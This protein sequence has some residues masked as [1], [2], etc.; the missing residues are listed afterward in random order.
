MGRIIPI[1]CLILFVFNEPLKA[2]DS[3]LQ[4]QL[5]KSLKGN[6]KDVEVDNLNNIYLISSTNQIKKLNSNF[7]SVAVFNDT[8]RFGNINSI[9]VN[10]PLKI[11][12]FYKEFSTIVVL[13]RFLNI[14]NTIDL[15]NQNRLQVSCI[16]TSYDNNIWLFDELENK[17]LK[18]D[19]LGNTLI[20]T[21]DFRMLFDNGFVTEKIIDDNGKLYCYNKLL[22]LVVFDYYGGLKHK[23]SITDLQYLQIHN[24]TLTAFK[25]DR[26][27]IFKL[28]LFTQ[29]EI[30]IN[31]NQQESTKKIIQKSKLFVLSKN[32]LSVFDIT[33]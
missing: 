22:G 30:K 8:R 15:R 5:T 27:A 11:L 31:I 32:E 28:N 14:V 23:Y 19:E 12:V 7:D 21:T 3:T 13:D 9:D 2:S 6:I 1:I 18:I 33:Q 16:A 26:L 4:L 25:K 10:N 17:V 20:E 24:E 29:E